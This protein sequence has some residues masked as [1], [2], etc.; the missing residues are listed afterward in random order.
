MAQSSEPIS[1]SPVSVDTPM[2]ISSDSHIDTPQSD[3]FSSISLKYRF[4]FGLTQDSRILIIGNYHR[5][6]LKDVEKYFLTVH[7]VM[8]PAELQQLNKDEKY[9]LICLDCYTDWGNVSIVELV[10]TAKLALN[11]SGS[12]VMVAA[13]PF[14]LESTLTKIRGKSKSVKGLSSRGYIKALKYAGFNKIHTFLVF[15]TLRSPDEYIDIGF[16]EVELPSYVSF[17]HKAFRWLGV[18][19]Y[20]H[21]DY[22][23]IASADS[24]SKF[25][26]FVAH[27]N[28]NMSGYVIPSQ[29]LRLQRFDLRNRGALI[30]MLSDSKKK[31][32]FVI[33]VAVSDTVNAVIARNKSFTDKIHSLAASAPAIVSLVPKTV[34]TFEY[35]NCPVYVEMR[36][37]GILVWKQ[38]RNCKVEKT[39]YKESF[40]FIYNFNSSTKQEMTVETKIFHDIIGNDL[41]RFRPAFREFSDIDTVILSIESQLARYFIGR[42]IFLVWGHGDYGYGNILCERATGHLRG[43]ID[44]D[45][46]VQ[47]ELPAV[48]FCNLLLQKASTEFDGKISQTMKKLQRMV[49]HSGKLDTTLAGYGKDDFNLSVT[50]LQ[51]YLCIAALRFI[52][53]SLPYSGEFN[54]KK[55]D[56]MNVL[57]AADYTIQETLAAGYGASA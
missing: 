26:T 43:V 42:K 48:D 56:Y 5:A 30:L 4:L 28:K 47:T 49:Q 17:V 55:D 54:M 8:Q 37:P 51:L 50:D 12:L 32:R 15:P 44:W 57:R 36:M 41:K 18:Y 34:M 6:L 45:T 39:A 25:D 53:R 11:A 29:Q 22:L 3:N 20:L 24:V 21:T 27:T 46:H 52:K 1:C 23:Y 16:G 9:D 40:E 7:F 35:R 33:R 14:S 31:H 19:K 38:S 2:G 10:G 13:N